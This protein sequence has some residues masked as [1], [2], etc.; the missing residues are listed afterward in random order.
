M[1]K[2]FSSSHFCRWIY[3]VFK[4]L[5]DGETFFKLASL[6]MDS[7]FSSIL[8]M[9]MFFQARISRDGEA[10]FKI[11]SLQMDIHSFQVY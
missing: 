1:L 5:R 4:C 6:A 7:W 8:E 3:I 2:V 9:V 11:T 10:F